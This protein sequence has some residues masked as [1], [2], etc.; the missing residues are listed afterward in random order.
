MPTIQEQII[1][2]FSSVAPPGM[3][4]ALNPF[5]SVITIR[6]FSDFVLANLYV[7]VFYYLTYFIVGG[8]LLP[9]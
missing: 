9:M 5:V 4:P 2:K 7:G 6:S 1:Q 8:N 3:E